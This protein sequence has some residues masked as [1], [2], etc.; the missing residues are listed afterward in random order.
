MNCMREEEGKR[1]ELERNETKMSEESERRWKSQES[2]QYS[3]RTASM[4]RAIK[5]KGARRANSA[6]W[7]EGAR[8]GS[9]RSDMRDNDETIDEVEMCNKNET[10]ERDDFEDGEERVAKGRTQGAQ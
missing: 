7:R 10:C 8:S 1:E 3:M 5:S 2:E 6:T 9:N 4:G